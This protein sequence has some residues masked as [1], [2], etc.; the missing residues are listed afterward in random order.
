METITDLIN[1]LKKIEHT[2]KLVSIKTRDNSV[3]EHFTDPRHPKYRSDIDNKELI[4]N[5]SI[6]EL[7]INKKKRNELD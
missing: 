7:T 4:V 3:Y 5:S 1:N 2:H 6:I